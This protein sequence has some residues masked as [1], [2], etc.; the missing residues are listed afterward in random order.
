MSQPH[1]AILGAGP[2]GLGAAYRLRRLE[3]A[4]VTVLE[5]SALV[6][7]NSGSFEI[8][9]Q[10]VDFGSHRLHAACAPEILA[11]IR[12]LVG[13]D[14]LDRPRHGRIRLRGRW[15]H[16]PLRPLDL[17]LRLDPAFGAGAL[18]DALLPRRAADPASDTFASALLRGL[19]PTICRDFYFPYARKIW[20][21]EP[22][23]LS[24]V[25]AQR[26]V[27]A[28]SARKLLR[29]VASAMPGLKPPGAGR[30]YYPRRGYG[31][32]SEAY[33]CAAQSAGAELRL[34]CRVEAVE[35]APATDGTWSVTAVTDDGTRT[36][37]RA[38]HVWS[39]L[40]ITLLARLVRPAPPP[41]VAG[42]GER[43]HY[44]AMLLVYLTLPVERFTEYDA[45]YLP[46]A[47]V[48]ITRLS[49]PKNYVG[50][51]TPPGRTT[52]CA[53]LPCTPGDTHWQTDDASLGALVAAD[54]GRAGLPL[55]C[56]PER[57]TVRRLSHAYPIYTVGYE[58]AF[59]ALDAWADG[60]PQLLSFGRQGLFA[61]DNT[62]HA[63]AMAYAAVA[64]LDGGTF[65]RT[66]WQ[67]Y[68][69]EF[70]THVVED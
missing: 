43:L 64:C 14:L 59:A 37:I 55:P 19:G 54:L 22:E 31:Q 20:G 39:T 56:A 67:T 57:V 49:E 32:I 29:R 5:R 41:E 34:G 18:R 27:S 24:A 3:R 13:D 47:D 66:R 6:G 40:P 4:R 21:R 12:T 7:G 26:R 28:N 10:R 38:D 1:V 23:E 69:R 46:G 60:L 30:F 9:G 50:D 44:R 52:L 8:D 62:H 35:H 33:A 17:L 42:A 65:D 36:T 16:F 48:A 68:R 25:Q 15:I 2:A 11:D 53:E 45:H 63:L 51:G 70:E 58:R 61:H